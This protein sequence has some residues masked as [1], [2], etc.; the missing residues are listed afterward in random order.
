[1]KHIKIV[2]SLLVV[3][4]LFT[5]LVFVVESYTTP[6]IQERLT[7]EANEA[8]FEVLPALAEDF[9]LT[10]EVPEI[11]DDYD[12]TGTTIL[13][14]FYE[15]GY[16]YIYEAEF[17]GYQSKIRYM[18]GV[19]EAGE[20]TGLKV[21]EQGD[22][23]G[24]GAEIANPDNWVQ[25]VGMSTNAA[26]NGEIDGLSGATITTDG[27][28]DSLAKVMDFHLNTVLGYT[29]SN[30][31]VAVEGVTG[32]QEVSKD[33]SVLEVI[34]TVEFE[35][36]YSNGPNVYNVTFKIGEGIKKLEIVTAT[37]TDTFGAHI[38]DPEFA[39]QFNGMTL[40]SAVNGEY[41]DL[42]GAT[43]P[44]TLG[45]FS[46]TLDALVAWHE[47]AYEGVAPE[48]YEEMITRYKE[49]V[50]VVDGTYL[51]V[52]ADYDLT[53]TFITQIEEVTPVDGLQASHLVISFTFPGY[54]DD[55]EAITSINLSDN[56]IN[57]LRIVSQ[58]ETA[59][60]GDRILESGFLSEFDDV[61]MYGGKY[62][63]YDAIGGSTKT[64]GDAVTA[65]Y[66]NLVDWYENEYLSTSNQLTAVAQADLELAFPGA[67]TFTSIYEEMAYGEGIGNIFEAYDGT[68]LLG[69]VYYAEADGYG[70]DPIKFVWGV[71]VSGVTEQIVII[72]HS[73]SWD[74]AEEYASYNGSAGY[75][76]NTTWLAN[77]FEGIT[78]ADIL[79]TSP[80]DAVAGV[81]TTGSGMKEVAEVIAQY[82]EDYVGGGN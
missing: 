9:D 64:T 45:A 2:L 60:I 73:E 25:F 51:D 53:D 35:S 44:V 69:Y 77:E 47:V 55:I 75:F 1:M 72:D 61:H 32:G 8:K 22:T 18:I 57:G 33:G 30:V 48:T 10:H 28:K 36:D 71:N 26:L 11:T 37:D 81:S 78:L 68:T 23:P 41:D 34:Y 17:Q 49:E 52:T 14:I 39:A 70:N 38:A 76:P 13:S 24:L 6:L 5:G 12:L 19:S 59:G 56:H 65:A 21:L 79:S 7:A 27:W 54:I 63:T 80:V 62:G 31:N 74:L 67:T 15:S 42:G 43:Y 4:V 16:G 46:E 50:S 20:I 82:H 29:Y 3:V 66:E 58:G 40:E